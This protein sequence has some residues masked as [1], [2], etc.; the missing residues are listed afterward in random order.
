M[1]DS[2]SFKWDVRTTQLLVK[3]H[4]MFGFSF[5]KISQTPPF[6]KLSRSALIGKYWRS[7]SQWG[8]P[9]FVSPNKPPSTKPRKKKEPKVYNKGMKRLAKIPVDY[10]SRV[11]PLEGCRLPRQPGFPFCAEHNHEQGAV[12]R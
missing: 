6:H 9:D 7:R 10:R 11:C 12:E 3:Y 1:N 8:D 4:E 2:K 5:K